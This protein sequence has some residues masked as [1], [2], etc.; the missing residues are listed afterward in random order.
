MYQYV[1]GKKERYV[2]QDDDS[3]RPDIQDNKDRNNPSK[4]AGFIQEKKTCPTWVLQMLGVIVV[5]AAVWLIYSVCNND[6]KTHK[7]R[8]RSGFKF[9]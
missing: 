4:P 8:S 2:P 6:T 1:N 5:L 3:R 9:Y 7:S